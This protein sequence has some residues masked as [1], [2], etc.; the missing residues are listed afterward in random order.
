VQPPAA[1]G[2]SPAGSTASLILRSLRSST[3]RAAAAAPV[4]CSM[5]KQ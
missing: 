5:S 4:R 1:G 3:L 2:R